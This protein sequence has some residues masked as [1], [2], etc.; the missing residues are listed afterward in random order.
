MG[1]GRLNR[2]TVAKSEGKIF[3][4]YHADTETLRKKYAEDPSVDTEEIVEID[5]VLGEAVTT[6]LLHR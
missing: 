6:G 2:R 1:I 5:A 3:S 4:V